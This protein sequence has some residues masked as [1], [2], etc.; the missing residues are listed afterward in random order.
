V[1][2]AAIGLLAL[3]SV[4]ANERLASA[5][6]A[7]VAGQDDRAAADARSARRFAPWS[8]DALDLQA[9]AL[10]HQGRSAEALALYRR[11]VDQDPGSWIAWTQLAAAS[12]G[13]ERRHAE[14]IALRLNPLA[15]R[16]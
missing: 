11:I 4:V 15:P 3:T 9:V 2:A 14:S 7:L 1:V 6:A 10:A 12:T 13:A 5:K 16:P 8:V